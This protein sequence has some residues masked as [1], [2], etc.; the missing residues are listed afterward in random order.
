MDGIEKQ[1]LEEQFAQRP[2]TW[3]MM[4][5]VLGYLGPYRNRFL[6]GVFME[7]LWVFF[8]ILPAKLV[9]VSIDDGIAR[10]SMK[11]LT[12][13]AA[14]ILASQVI[15][16]F[17]GWTEVR[18]IRQAGENMLNNVRRGVFRHVQKLS[19]S[20]FDRNPIGRLVTR[21][22]SDVDVLNE[23]FAAGA[24]TIFMDVLTMGSIIAIMV[25]ASGVGVSTAETMAITKMAQRR[26]AR[27]VRLVTIPRIASNTSATGSSNTR[28]KPKSSS[29]ANDRYSPSAIL[30]TM[31]DAP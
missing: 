2:M 19:M 20:Y 15:T 26:N 28:P 7:V 25:S 29:V 18:W 11:V 14:G 27:S 1:E 24:M 8:R 10:S 3:S 21:L 12:L 16:W 17:L 13:A 23:M 5:R 22:T 30:G 31:S 9:K 6:A 4:R